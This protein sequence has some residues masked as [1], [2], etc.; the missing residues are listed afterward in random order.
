MIKQRVCLNSDENSI[1][2]KI[3]ADDGP[4]CEVL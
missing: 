2:V 3:T 1:T 4:I